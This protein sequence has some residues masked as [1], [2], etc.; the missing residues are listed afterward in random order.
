MHME[1]LSLKSSCLVLSRTWGPAHW[2]LLSMLLLK[3]V[4]AVQHCL[5]V[6]AVLDSKKTAWLRV[7]SLRS[8][9]ASCLRCSTS[10]GI[11]FLQLFLVYMPPVQLVLYKH[12]QIPLQLHEHH[13]RASFDLRSR[14]ELSA[15]CKQ[16]TSKQDNVQMKLICGIQISYHHGPCFMAKLTTGA[17]GAVPSSALPAPAVCRACFCAS[18]CS[19]RRSLSDCASSCASSSAY[20]IFFC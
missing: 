16:L 11:Q 6:F 4:N 20:S 19:D 12:K 17:M 13:V 1:A 8:A 7:P 14:Q 2:Y 5:H 15:K 10:E 9:G 3:L 18:E